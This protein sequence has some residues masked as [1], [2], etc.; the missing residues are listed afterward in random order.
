MSEKITF[1][2]L[3][4]AIA[5]ETD[6]SKKFTHDFLKNFVEV[7]NGGL[8]EDG[9]VNI[10]GF[11]KF[12]LRHVDEREGYNPQTNEKMTIPAHNKIVFKPY[13]DLREVVNAPYAHMEPTLL[14][15]SSESGIKAEHNADTTS[16]DSPNKNTEHRP[17]EVIPFAE[18][19]DHTESNQQADTPEEDSGEQD[20]I[21]TAPPTTQTHSDSVSAGDNDKDETADDPFGFGAPEE[22]SDHEEAATDHNDDDIVEFEAQKSEEK[23]TDLDID[24]FITSI[25]DSDSDESLEEEIADISESEDTVEVPTDEEDEEN[26]EEDEIFASEEQTEED[27]LADEIDTLEETAKELKEGQAEDEETKVEDEPALTTS[28]ST[29]PTTPKQPGRKRNSSMPYVAAAVITLL[30]IAGGAWYYSTLSTD[31]ISLTSADQTT[32]SMET[33]NQQND[34]QQPADNT[35]QQQ[36]EQDNDTQNQTDATD[37]EQSNSEEATAS[38]EE[39]E[40]DAVEIEEG[41]TLWSLAE[42]KYGNPR[43]WPWIYGNNGS[44]EDPNVIYAGNSLSVPLPS[45]P[46]NS[47]NATDSVGVAKG[48]IATYEWYKSNEESKARNHLWAAKRYHNDIQQL[49]DVPIDRADLSFANRA[50]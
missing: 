10:A 48:F 15:N 27:I 7:I 23:N 21:P 42:E 12:K 19:S 29:P 6:N 9:K 32:S 17:D 14:D 39:T 33:E 11:G 16:N 3:I 30:L 25:E 26:E 34:S 38:Q 31:G 13:K 41:Q 49:A 46:Q 45:G 28:E 47:L 35:Q 43:L 8:E 4:E 40:T 20:F 1:G 24:D 37:S 2:E 22:N 18:E 36:A 44:L 5:E 50:R